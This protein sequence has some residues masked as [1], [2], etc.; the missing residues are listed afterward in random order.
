MS[1]ILAYPIGLQDFRTLREEGYVYIDK[2]RY[3]AA[4]IRN[5]ARYCFLARPRRFGKSLFLSTL[6]CFFE[7]RRELF[8]GLDIESLDWTWE[9]YPVLRLDLNSHSYMEQ[10]RLDSVLDNTFRNW[11]RKYGVDV[12]DDDYSQR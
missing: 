1:E 10:G 11:E 8:T 2:T 12:K 5:K 3:I 9:S 4:L 7:G 6:Q